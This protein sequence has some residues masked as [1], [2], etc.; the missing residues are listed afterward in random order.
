MTE[1]AGRIAG[2][3]LSPRHGLAMKPHREALARADHG[4]DGC[5]HARPGSPRQVLL[6]ESETLQEFG[7]A[8]GALK[9]NIVTEGIRVAGLRP[10]TRLRAGEA[11]LEVTTDCAPCAFV[12]SVQPDL[13]EKIRGRRGT[14]AR[15]IEGGTLHIG[16]AIELLGN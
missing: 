16:D 2:I 10:G 3:F 6:L 8:P 4:L 15:V 13:R 7:V 5:A 12:D 9:E 11:M 1:D 14:L